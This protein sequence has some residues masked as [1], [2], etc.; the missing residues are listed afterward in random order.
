MKRELYWRA[1]YE[2][3]S[4]LLQY[5]IKDGKQIENKYPDINREKL[6]RFDLLDY[7]TNKPIYSLW[8]QDGQRLIYRRRTLLP[9]VISPTRPKQVI[10]I[11]GY[12]HVVMTGAGPRKFKVVNYLYEDGSIALDDDR[13]NLELYPHE[14]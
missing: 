11:V 14:E 3:E 7:A 2:D 10:Y 5:E 6:V 9:A 12:S 1:V 13:G 8:L 4:Q